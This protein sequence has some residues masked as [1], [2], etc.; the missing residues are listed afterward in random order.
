[1]AAAAAHVDQGLPYGI[2]RRER[3]PTSASLGARDVGAKRVYS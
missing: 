2:A 3:S 1:M